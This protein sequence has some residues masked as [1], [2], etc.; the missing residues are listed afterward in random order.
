MGLRKVQRNDAH[1][2]SQIHFAR[3]CVRFYRLVLD[4]C[5][6]YFMML[7]SAHTFASGRH[8]MTRASKSWE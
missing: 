3:R 2:Q 1:V 6:W 7:L 4:Q 5:E 8:S